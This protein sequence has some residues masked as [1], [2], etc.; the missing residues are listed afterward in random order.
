MA[1]KRINPAQDIYGIKVTLLG[2]KP[3]I[4]R[5]LLVPASMTLAKLHDVLQTAMGW[6]DCHMH[7]FRAG[8]RH[9]GVPDP[10]DISMGMQVEN[11]RTV[12]LS[13]VL[14]RPGAKMVYTYDFG[15]NWEHA[16]VLEKQ[17]P[18][19]P[20]MSDPICIDGNLACPPDDCGGI[21]GFYELLDALADPN[22]EQHQEMRDWVRGE[23]DPQAF[24][25][26]EVNRK[27]APRRRRPTTVKK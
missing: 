13:S 18:L 10:E 7:E 16:V 25:V 15:D 5:R 4:W 8:E 6:H 9:F 12:K 19:L 2:T 24:S 26:E 3:P 17:M 14:R 21:P 11:E 1:T 20:D 27:L 23:Y 22:H